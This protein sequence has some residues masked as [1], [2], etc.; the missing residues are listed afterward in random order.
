[1]HIIEPPHGNGAYDDKGCENLRA[2]A[3]RHGQHAD[4]QQH[5]EH[6]SIDDG[7]LWT[8]FPAEWPKDK[9][10]NAQEC[11]KKGHAM[12]AGFAEQVVYDFFPHNSAHFRLSLSKHCIERPCD[13]RWGLIIKIVK[14]FLFDGLSLLDGFMCVKSFWPQCKEQ[15]YW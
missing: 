14:N 1:M 6:D 9:D 12:L 13:F 7:D 5:R 8:P 15:M 10:L 3:W 11:E 4:N 2:W